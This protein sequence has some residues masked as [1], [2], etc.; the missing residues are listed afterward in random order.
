MLEWD[1]G[2]VITGSH[3]VKRKNVMY[4]LLMLIMYKNHTGMGLHAFEWSLD[5]CDFFYAVSN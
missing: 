5:M 2:S 1:K 4:R 3:C